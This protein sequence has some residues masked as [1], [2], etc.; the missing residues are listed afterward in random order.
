MSGSYGLLLVM[1]AAG[2]M[3]CATAV[4]NSPTS[5]IASPTPERSASA[6]P[7]TSGP[8][9]SSPA[10]SGSVV[11]SP[12]PLMF[13]CS[14]SEARCQ[15]IPA[16]TY[17]TA[18]VYAFLPGLIV[19]LPD[20][21]SSW[22]QDAGEFRLQRAA[23]PNGNDVLMFW[24]D[25]AA[26]D[27]HGDPAVGVGMTPEDLV[28]FLRDDP[29]L[30]TSQPQMTTIG[31]GLPAQSLVISAAPNGPIDDPECPGEACANPLMDFVHWGGPFGIVLNSHED[32]SLTCPCSHNVRLYLTTIGSQSDPHT[33]I[34]AVVA[35]AHDP[36]A[37]LASFQTEV[38]PILNSLRLP[39]VVIEN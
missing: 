35:Y 10:E 12:V 39:D 6:P 11:P 31:A 7:A 15:H 25:V 17:T 14:A 27:V 19:T 29:R 21:W 34:A 13:G 38:Q 37:E 1:L 20:G 24:R 30:I 9:V 8:R 36:A 18:G 28:A 33:F 32:P 22:E 4:P 2:A 23:D 26:V 3:G 16:G 5:P